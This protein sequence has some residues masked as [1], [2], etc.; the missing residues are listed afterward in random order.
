MIH[1]VQPKFDKSLLAATQVQKLEYFERKI[2]AHTHLTN[3]FHLAQDNIEFAC[4]GE[5]VPI[6]GPSGV[7]TK[8]IGNRLWQ[9]YQEQGATAEEQGTGRRN[10]NSIGI[11][12]PSQA[13]RIDAE[14]WKR[15]LGEILC[16][17]GDLLIDRK[18][19]VPPCE[20]TLTHPIQFADP[21]KGGI[22]TLIRATVS[23]LNQ[24]KT[25]LVLINQAERLFPE[26]DSA[27][28]T[29][30]Q[31]I[32]ID[33]AAQTQTRLVL[34]GG[35]QLVRASCARN[36]WLRRQHIVHF[37]RYDI[38][39]KEEYATFIDALE[40]LL[41]NIPSQQRLEKLSADGAWKL[42]MSSV[43]CIGSLKKTLLMAFQHSLRTGEKMTESF[44]L[45][46]TQPNVAAMEIAR[47]V[48]LGEA[49]L[50]DV[51]FSEVERALNIG[52]V[53][54]ETGSTKGSASK[55]N[56]PPAAGNRS[57]FGARRIGERKPSRDPIGER[58]AKRA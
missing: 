31:Q 57:T 5:I 18:I 33:L 54:E 3:A 17:G 39:N 11:E 10:A 6:V 36:N 20:F 7:G 45:N 26:S 4:S 1:F 56:R 16:R 12:A 24:R 25:K 53:S 52:S 51:E 44:I 55:T 32:L 30:S 14:Y 41:A 23:M 15:L 43:G 49:L 40:F 38:R 19:Y 8:L 2:L 42:Y 27:G 9:L 21:L 47:E 22:D 13:G 50:T 35:Y 48:R 58:H 34:I 46:F 28:C 29:R 37:R